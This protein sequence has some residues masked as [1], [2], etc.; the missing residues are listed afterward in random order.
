[1]QTPGIQLIVNS[2]TA[3][4]LQEKVISLAKQFGVD[5]TKAQATMVV[6]AETEK[7]VEE[8]PKKE[9]KSKKAEVV[10]TTIVEE[11]EVETQEDE[12]ITREQITNS[13]QALS[14]VSNIETVKEVLAAFGAKKVSDL[15]ESEYPAVMAKIREVESR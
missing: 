9:K 8:K 4:E 11:V 14:A 12:T 3:E 2:T 5:L 1:M 13:L 7:V 15:K 10:E 6:E